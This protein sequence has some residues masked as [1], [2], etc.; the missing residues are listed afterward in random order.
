MIFIILRKG[1]SL[2]F[3]HFFSVASLHVQINTAYASVCGGRYHADH[4]T[5][6][7]PLNNSEPVPIYVEPTADS[8][9]EARSAA[10]I[11]SLFHQNS[12]DE[13]THFLPR[14]HLF[15]TQSTR[16]RPKT[17]FGHG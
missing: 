13:R 14:K 6:H 12:L 7:K 11:A 10:I 17:L 5:K 2:A 15:T 16:N 9:T 3:V 4:K 1:G 8:S